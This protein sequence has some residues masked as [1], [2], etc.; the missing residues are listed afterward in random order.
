MEKII[1]KANEL[2]IGNI[3]SY[4]GAECF[5]LELRR[6]EAE[7]GYFT[8]SIGFSRAYSSN[9]F[10]TPI[11]ITKEYLIKFGFKQFEITREV[12]APEGWRFSQ[13]LELQNVGGAFIKGRN[14]VIWDV[15]EGL[16]K[17]KPIIHIYE[18][19]T[20]YPDNNDN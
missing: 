11:P 6:N 2:K 10:P 4:H 20:K 7:F 5:I 3:F 18:L 17:I 12:T 9:D 15:P 16:M 13:H 19:Y 1:T 8:D 14:N